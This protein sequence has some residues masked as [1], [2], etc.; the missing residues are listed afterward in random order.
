MSCQCRNAHVAVVRRSVSFRLH[1]V[2]AA[3]TDQ[4]HSRV[5]PRCRHNRFGLAVGKFGGGEIRWYAWSSDD[6]FRYKVCEGVCVCVVPCQHSPLFKIKAFT[7]QVLL[8]LMCFIK[9][10]DLT[11]TLKVSKS[12]G[13]QK[14]KTKTK[15]N[16][17]KKKHL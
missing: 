1:P 13:R 16:K 17:Q 2:S 3:L 10:F 9:K 4:S 8:V 12:H 15:Q 11:L 14:E 6:D 5:Q 7:G